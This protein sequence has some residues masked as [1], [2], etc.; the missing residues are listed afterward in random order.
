MKL[1]QEMAKTIPG[2][3]LQASEAPGVEEEIVLNECVHVL[4]CTG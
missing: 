2:R 3:Q 4:H 1:E